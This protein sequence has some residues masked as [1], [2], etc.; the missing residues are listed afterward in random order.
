MSLGKVEIIYKYSQDWFTQCDLL[1][2][3][4]SYSACHTSCILVRS[5]EILVSDVQ[6]RDRELR[7]RNYRINIRD[8]IKHVSISNGIGLRRIVIETGSASILIRLLRY[9]IVS[10]TSST[11]WW[12]NT[13]RIV[14]KVFFFRN[15]KYPKLTY[16]P[17][18]HFRNCII[19]FLYSYLIRNRMFITSTSL[20]QTVPGARY[21][22]SYGNQRNY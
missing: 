5:C 1:P 4:Y 15:Q 17:L 10:N 16:D 18:I 6:T 11:S 19:S 9:R 3:Q 13:A 14:S 20:V 21:C 7:N 22:N 12:S 8:R 2:R